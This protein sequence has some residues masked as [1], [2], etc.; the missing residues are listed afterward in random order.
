MN[1]SQTNMRVSKQT[2]K[3]Y[4]TVEYKNPKVRKEQKGKEMGEEKTFF[5]L[6]SFL[7][8]FAALGRSSSMQWRMR[9]KRL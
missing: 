5:L 8:S 1:V 2:Q 7:F 4:N 6:R 9:R 3:Y